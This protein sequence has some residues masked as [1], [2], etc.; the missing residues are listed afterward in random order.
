MPAL[1]TVGVGKG[2]VRKLKGGI[3]LVHNKY[4]ATFL[5]LLANH[6]LLFY[7]I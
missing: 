5:M 4:N 6:R 1:W 2:M 7:K 3:D